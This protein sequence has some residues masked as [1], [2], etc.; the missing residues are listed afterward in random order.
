MEYD[1][2]GDAVAAVAAG[3]AVAAAAIMTCSCLSMQED[4]VNWHQDM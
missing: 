4:L 1:Y 3:D 2:N